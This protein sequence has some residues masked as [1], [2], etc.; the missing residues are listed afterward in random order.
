VINLETEKP[1]TLAEAPQLIP[2][3]NAVPGMES[4]KPLHP[5][6]LYNWAT[7][8]KHGVTLEV[9]P[10]G[11]ILVTSREALQRFFA[12]LAECR[13]QRFH[14]RDR[15]RGRESSL[16]RRPVSRR[17]LEAARAKLAAQHGI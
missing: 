13:L 14:D 10:L 5:R 12:R 7:K 3:I 2:A 6:T 15:G 16:R 1:V 8:G 17:N 9:V 4:R 11:G